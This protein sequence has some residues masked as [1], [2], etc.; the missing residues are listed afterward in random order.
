MEKSMSKDDRLDLA[1]KLIMG[2]G[3]F[4]LTIVVPFDTVMRY[5][6]MLKG[7]E[8]KYSQLK[9]SIENERK[10]AEERMLSL[11]VQVDSLQKIASSTLAYQENLQCLADNIYYEAADEPEEGRIAVAQVTLN[12]MHDPKRPKTICGVVYE[13]KQ[14]S[15]TLSPLDREKDPKI[16]DP[17]LYSE[18]MT[19]AKKMLT[20]KLKSHIIGRDVLFYHA[21]YVHPA[22]ADEHEFVVTIGNHLFYRK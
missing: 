14:F 12:R 19:I 1:F 8:I 2:L 13:Y 3:V 16:Y 20:H 6:D 18:A 15:W 10:D 7:A 22:W 11:G 17:K 21:N 5:S 9:S 4:F